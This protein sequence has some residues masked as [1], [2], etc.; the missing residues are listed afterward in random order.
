LPT[1]SGGGAPT[2]LQ[3]KDS[4]VPDRVRFFEVI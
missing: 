3:F 4:W 2:T 1:D